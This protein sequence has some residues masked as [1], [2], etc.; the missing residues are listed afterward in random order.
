MTPTSSV[1]APQLKS[2]CVE[3]TALDVNVPGTLGAVVSGV[4]ALLM[5]ENAPALFAASV[6]RTR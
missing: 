3:E 4:V 6:A 5:F 2:I 1:A